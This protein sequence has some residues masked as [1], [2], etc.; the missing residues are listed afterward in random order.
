[1]EVPKEKWIDISNGIK[2]VSLDKQKAS[3]LSQR[4]PSSALRRAINVSLAV[5]FGVL[6]AL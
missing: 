6:L 1:M 5:L 4:S 3:A 2:I